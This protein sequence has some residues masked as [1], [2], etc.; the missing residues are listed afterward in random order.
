MS[1]L[2]DHTPEARELVATYDVNLSGILL[3]AY[4][5]VSEGRHGCPI[6]EIAGDRCCFDMTILVTPQVNEALEGSDK[7]ACMSIHA[8]TNEMDHMFTAIPHH[9]GNSM[10][11]TLIDATYKQFLEMYHH[12]LPHAFVG[13]RA[14]MVAL[15]QELSPGNER[16][17]LPEHVLDDHSSTK[18]ALARDI[19]YYVP[20]R[21]VF[22]YF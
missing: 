7:Q 3:A 21:G 18:I 6:Y 4:A 17:Y 5:E 19:P 9:S 1:E 20:G 8:P 16:Y 10:Q 14:A 2:F 11:D 12:H 13:S 15:M 22:T